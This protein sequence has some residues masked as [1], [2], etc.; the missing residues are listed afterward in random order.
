MEAELISPKDPVDMGFRMRPIAWSRMPTALQSRFSKKGSNFILTDSV[1]VLWDGRVWELKP[2]FIWDGSSIPFWLSAIGVSRFTRGL[3]LF[4]PSLFH[5]A[6]WRG[7]LP[8]LSSNPRKNL[9]RYTE[10]YFEL[11]LACGYPRW[12]MAVQLRVLNMVSTFRI[13]KF[14]KFVDKPDPSQVNILPLPHCT[15][16]YDLDWQIEIT[17]SA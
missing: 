2:G 10:F 9:K 15:S 4:I 13:G 5:D 6:G 1:K 8:R 16:K 14:T 3:E 17:G 12:K 7:T 11:G